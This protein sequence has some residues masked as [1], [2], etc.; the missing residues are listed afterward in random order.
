MVNTIQS[1]E[2]YKTIEFSAEHYEKEQNNNQVFNRK[3]IL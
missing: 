2:W 1:G 3:Q